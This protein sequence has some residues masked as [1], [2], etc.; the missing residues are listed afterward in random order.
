MGA[1]VAVDGRMIDVRAGK[2]SAALDEVLRQLVG[3]VYSKATFIDTPVAGDMDIKKILAG[4]MG[5]TEL[6]NSQA[7]ANL[8]QYLEAQKQTHQATSLG[9]I[10]RKYSRPPF[11]WREQDTSALVALLIFRQMAVAKMDGVTLSANEA[12]LFSALTKRQNFDSMKIEKRVRINDV[13][14]NKG[15]RIL[16]DFIGSGSVPD[17]EDGLI[18]AIKEALQKTNERCTELLRIEYAQ[19]RPYPG[20]DVVE[21]GRRIASEILEHAKDNEDFLMTFNRNEDALLDF[22]EDFEKVEGFF[23]NQQRIFDDSLKIVSMMQ[24]EQ[25]YLQGNA[26]VMSALASIKSILEMTKPYD[27][28]KDLGGLNSIILSAHKSALQ[29]KKNE[30]FNRVDDVKVAIEDYAQGKSAAKKTAESTISELSLKKEQAHAASTMT[31]IEAYIAQLTQLKDQTLIQIDID[32]ENARKPK[33]ELGKDPLPA[34]PPVKLPK[35]IRRSD[36]CPGTK[37]TSVDQID[38]YV[39]NIRQMLLAGLDECGSVRMGD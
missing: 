1:R 38:S 15:R 36:A 5:W 9:D 24:D 14:L 28:I 22:S 33:P 35:M 21:D 4:T 20:R 37:L 16:K 11:G 8:D 31:Q 30:M 25:I 39:E 27:K 12:K 29:A 23:P 26:E 13:L 18:A 3:V 34:Q 17:D 6:A 2:A 7:V 10:Q 19:Q 32:E